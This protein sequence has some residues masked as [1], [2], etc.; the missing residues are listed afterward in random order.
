MVA[1]AGSR[2]ER[3][4]EQQP[5]PPAPVDGF[6][7]HRR[8]DG[9]GN[10]RAGAVRAFRGGL[11]RPPLWQEFLFIGVSYLLYSL[12]RNGVPT[13]SV[14]ARHRAE[15]L[16]ALERALHIDVELSINRFVASIHWLSL[17]ADYWYA[18]MHF[19][20]TVGVLVWLYLRHPARYRSA[21]S[22]LLATNL[23]ALVTFWGF[24]LAPPRMLSAYGFVDT[25]VRDHIWGSWGSSGMDTA[26]NQYAAMPSLH[27]GWALWCSVVVVTLVRRRWLKTLAVA[28]PVVTLLVILA[29]ANHFVLDAVGGAAALGC[30]LAVQPL[31][32]RRPALRP[33]RS[34]LP[35][36]PVPVVYQARREAVTAGR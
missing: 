10:S 20:V 9:R 7:D 1:T 25:V 12:I 5:A 21:R 3:P 13:H 6:V 17:T 28:Y 16:Y 23:I 11:R 19:V 30:G 33:N 29:T 34:P 14:G 18:L 32:F 4:Q 24:S 36:P 15:A 31:L 22:V 35:P 8:G 26:S 27:I 2:L